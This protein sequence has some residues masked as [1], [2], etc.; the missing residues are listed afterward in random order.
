ML[1]PLLESDESQASFFDVD[2]SPFAFRRHQGTYVDGTH[3]LIRFKT[4][5][6]RRSSCYT[7]VVS[8]HKT[9]SDSDSSSTNLQQPLEEEVGFTLS[10]YSQSR[11]SISE[12]PKIYPFREKIVGSWNGRNCGGNVSNS[13]FMNNPMFSIFIASSSASTSSP[14]SRPSSSSLSEVLSGTTS[15]SVLL[16]AAK[17]LPIQILLVYTSSSTNASAR[18]L[19]DQRVSHLVSGD[20][21]SS[22][23]PYHHGV[24]LLETSNLKPGFYTLILSCFEPGSKGS[25]PFSL[26]IDSNSRLKVENIPLEG[27]GMYSRVLKGEWD[28]RKGTAN[29][30]P[31]SSRRVNERG[32]DEG[33]FDRNPSWLIRVG[34]NQN[35]KNGNSISG[36]GN[37]TAKFIIRLN[38]IL[39][40]GNREVR[41]YI[42]ASIFS[43]TRNISASNPRSNTSSNPSSSSDLS[44][45]SLS[46]ELFSS[47]PYDE[48]V[49]G[50]A[51]DFKNC[52]LGKGEYALVLSTFKPGWE[53]SF[54]V[55]LYSD[56]AIDCERVR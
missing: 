2:L 22:S 41:P 15:I 23:G 4:N 52:R 48:H 37:S 10:A 33:R 42:N 20:V 29:G 32:V 27:A 21:I 26:T 56:K 35:E 14:R 36:G 46:Q 3:N 5:T 55:D 39:E 16:E 24:S 18:S 50:V 6:S 13:T 40:D 25:G 54:R 44:D 51:V 1:E 12:M 34:M 45:Y 38:S 49:S 7:L 43:I 30:S 28:I 8:R 17:D 53:G 9:S 31:S 47:G 19:T 11:L